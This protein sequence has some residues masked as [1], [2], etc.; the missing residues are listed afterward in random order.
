MSHLMTCGDAH[1]LHVGRPGYPNHWL[2]PTVLNTGRSLLDTND[3][4]F[5]EEDNR[6][7]I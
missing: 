6:T 3:R 1:K 5:D 7:K 4:G 2:V